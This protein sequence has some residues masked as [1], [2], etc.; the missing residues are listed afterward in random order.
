MR[1]ATNGGRQT[2]GKAGVGYRRVS[3]EWMRA[4]SIV[5]T[6][7]ADLPDDAIT[8]EGL[9]RWRCVR[10]AMHSPAEPRANW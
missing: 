10:A 5:E 2:A 9:R 4:A 6:M 1:R 7:F 8:L 3:R